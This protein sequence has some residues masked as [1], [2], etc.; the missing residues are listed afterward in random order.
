[1]R[2]FQQRYQGSAGLVVTGFLLLLALTGVISSAQ[3][4]DATAAA[5]IKNFGK[6][7]DNYYRGSQPDHSQL[8]A[9][10]AMGVKTIIDLRQDYV[11]RE[12]RWATELG[13][14]YFHIPLKPSRPP[15]KEQTQYFL[16]LV[17]DPANG[18]VYV[19]CKVG[20]HRTGA[21]TA[22]YRITHDGWTA[23]QAFAE[24]K[25]YD[26]DDGIFGGPASQKR[27]VFDFYEQQ[28]KAKSAATQQ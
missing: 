9:L 6:V 26:F 2:S 16:G 20:R 19:H 25:Q 10:K 3:K 27:F 12:R 1:M 23:D 22:V 21:L 24:M 5:P 28:K 4:S 13:L 14:N 7:N 18:P 8:A 15:T 11:A 17:N